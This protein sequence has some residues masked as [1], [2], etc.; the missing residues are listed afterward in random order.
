MTHE[1]L[2]DT[3]NRYARRML[4]L[5]CSVWVFAATLPAQ[6]P[7][8][9]PAIMVQIKCKPGTAQPWGAEFEKEILPSIQEAISK[10]DGITKFTYLEAALPGQ[11]FDYVLVFEVKTLASLDTKQPFPHYVVL[12]R[13]VGQARGLQILNEM[14]GWEQE[15]KVTVVHSHSGQP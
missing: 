1:K 3:G 14:T 2:N 8:S 11:S 6:S 10:G 9:S 4:L 5:F 15:V 13:R 7:A 12:F